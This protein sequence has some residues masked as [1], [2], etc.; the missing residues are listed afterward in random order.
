MTFTSPKVE[1]QEWADNGSSLLSDPWSDDWILP[2]SDELK[3]VGWPGARSALVVDAREVESPPKLTVVP[4]TEPSAGDDPESL[5]QPEPQDSQADWADDDVIT[6]PDRPGKRQRI[7]R[8]RRG[9]HGLRIGVAMVARAY[10]YFVAVTLAIALI[11]PFANGW[12]PTTV[13]TNSMAPTL[14][15]GDVVAFAEFDGSLLDI[16]TIVQ[17][18]DA[19]REDSTITHRIIGL[20]PDGTYETKGDANQ[21]ADSVKVATSSITGVSHMVLPYVGLPHFWLATGQYL[22]LV[23]WILATMAAAAVMTPRFEGVRQNARSAPKVKKWLA[24]LRPNRR[25]TASEQSEA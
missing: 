1:E 5:P 21:G 22:P 8:H 19:V 20:N 7:R 14:S 4:D 17:F 13:M 18:E 25:S 6:K 24:R 9:L 15:E 12:H 16:G 10:W 2:T 23:A 11:V 3:A